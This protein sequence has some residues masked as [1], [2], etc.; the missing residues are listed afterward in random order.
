MKIAVVTGSR[1]DWNGLGMVAKCLRADYQAGVDVIAIGQHADSEESLQ[2]IIADGFDPKLCRTNFRDDMAV[3]AGAAALAA[4]GALDALGWPDMVLV[5]GDRFEILGAATAAALKNIP[6]AHIGGGDL[7]EGSID[8]KLRYAI[9]ALSSVHFVTNEES[10]DRL[11]R[12]GN[13]T[14]CLVG[15][16]ALDRIAATPIVS[17]ET[18]FK[19]LALIPSKKNVL[20]AYHAATRE[21]RPW[22]SCAQ[23]LSALDGIDASFLVL[24]TNADTGSDAIAQLL[25]EF[26]DGAFPAA[27]R[28]WRGN[29]SPEL[30]YSALAHFDCMVGN[31]S[32]GLVETASFGINV[33][34]IGD[35]QTG[36]LAPRNVRTYKAD[37]AAIAYGVKMALDLP[38][39]PQ[40]NPYGDGHSA[41]RIAK[42]IVEQVQQ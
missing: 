14:L 8:N 4:S 2:T 29:L 18:L 34:N 6:L 40:P 39:Q 19:E 27:K 36:R 1:A 24:G 32:A 20:V 22:E 33:V 15:N 13:G 35:R 28:Q 41:P 9:T 30:F 31:S 42:T 38:R 23:M 12:I 5:L 25:A 26:C 7:T 17:R 21:A 10:R 37:E 3:G 16:P 11:R